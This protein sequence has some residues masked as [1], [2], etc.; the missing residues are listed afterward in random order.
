MFRTAPLPFQGQKRR[1]ATSFV[2]VLNELKEKKEVKIVVD[3]F[4]GSGLLSHTAKSILP[5]SRVVYNDF[6]DYCKRLH[7]VECTNKLLSDIRI[8]AEGQPPGKKIEQ[9]CRAAILQRIKRERAIK[10]LV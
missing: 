5:D 4:G 10:P 9:A 8:I 1:F 3:L 6:D 7:N 2:A